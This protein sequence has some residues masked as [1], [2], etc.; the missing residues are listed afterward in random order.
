MVA[1]IKEE[2][3][4][5][6]VHHI[7]VWRLDDHRI[8]FEAHLDFQ[9]DISLSESNSVLEVLETKLHDTFD[10]EHTTLQCEYSRDD[11]KRVIV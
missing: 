11:D 7:H 4:I 2:R 9:E 5:A 1:L 3:A 6:G 8:H 10:I